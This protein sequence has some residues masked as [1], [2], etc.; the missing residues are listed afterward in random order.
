MIAKV[1][2]LATAAPTP[3]THWIRL[4]RP[5]GFDFEPVQFCGLEIETEEGGIEYPMSLASSPTRPWLE[6]GS[7][8]SDSPW[9]RAFAALKVGDEVEVD[10]AYGHFVLDETR[11]AI[12]VA[13]GIG[14]TPLKGMAEYHADKSLPTQMRLL[15]SSRDETEIAFRKEV[16]ALA[17]NDPNLRVT[18]TLTRPTPD[19]RGAKGRIGPE[20]L[21][22]A[23]EG[24]HDPVWY[25]CG[26]PE[27]V[28]ATLATLRAQGVRPE[29]VLYERFSG[30]E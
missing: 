14:I 2:V 11:D 16:D 3:S 13:G 30:Y 25:A 10:G 17:R 27:M 22:A 9:K 12:L 5:P 26:K 4:E 29:D 8:M 21:A 15:Y 28:T 6:F 7:R 19:W 23:A 18:H 1:K 20:M 24:L